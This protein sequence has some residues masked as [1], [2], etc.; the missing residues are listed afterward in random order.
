MSDMRRA[1]RTGSLVYEKAFVEGEPFTG[2]AFNFIASSNSVDRYGDVIEQDWVLEDYWK[3]PVLLWA[4]QT[5]EAPVGRVK[6]FNVS[7]DG[8]R[9]FAEI[10]LVPDEIADEKTKYL[11]LMVQHKFLNAVSVGFIPGAET[12]R[13]DEKGNWAGYTYTRNRLVELSLV[14]VPANQDAVQ[15]EARALGT[16]EEHVRRILATGEE[17]QTAPGLTLAR[18]RFLLADLEITRLRSRNFG[19]RIGHGS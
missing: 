16:T 10:E 8:S 13:R 11:A 6:T 19:R 3:N 2:K 14:S 15:Q 12:D 17:S 4:H 7:P 1:A 9:T 18:R 5:R